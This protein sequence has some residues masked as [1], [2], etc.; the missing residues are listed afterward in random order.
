MKKI[1]LLTLFVLLSISLTYADHTSEYNLREDTPCGRDTC[2]IPIYGPIL[3]GQVCTSDRIGSL[4]TAGSVAEEC[5]GVFVGTNIRNKNEISIFDRTNGGTAKFYKQSSKN[6][7]TEMGSG[8]C[9]LGQVCNNGCQCETVDGD[10]D[11]FLGSSFAHYTNSNTQID[12]NDKDASVFPGADEV[13]NLKDDNCDGQVDEGDVCKKSVRVCRDTQEQDISNKVCNQGEYCSTSSFNDES[14]CKYITQQSDIGLNEFFAFFCDE[15]LQ[16]GDY[17]CIRFVESSFRVCTVDEQDL[18]EDNQDNDCDGRIDNLDTDCGFVVAGCNNGQL[19]QGEQCDASNLN[20]ATCQTVSSSFTGGSLS[21][22]N[23]CQFDTSQC[24]TETFICSPEEKRV[25]Y[26]AD[27][28]DEVSNYLETCGINGQWGSCLPQPTETC[29]NGDERACP[30]VLGICEG[31]TQTCS[32]GQWQAC[33]YGSNFNLVDSCS[34]SLDNNCDGLIDENCDCNVGDTKGCSTNTGVCN[35]GTQICQENGKWSSICGG[36]TLPGLEICDGIDNNCEGG[37]DEGCDCTNQGSTKNCGG[38]NQGVCKEGTQTCSLVNGLLKW[39]VCDGVVLPGIEICDNI[40]N[41]CNGAVD[42][43]CQ[44]STGDSRSCGTPI[45]ACTRGTQECLNSLW[46]VCLGAILPINELCGDNI[47]NDCDGSTDESCTCNEGDTRACALNDGVCSGLT[48]TCSNGAFTSCNYT[49]IQNY[50]RIETSCLDNKDND[51]DGKIDELDTNCQ[52][53]GESCSD[54]TNDNEC[55]TNKPNRCNDGVL[56]NKCAICGCDTEELCRPDGSCIISRPRTQPQQTPPISSKDSDGDGLTDEEE[57]A[58]GYDPFNPD[59]DGD[60]I[61]D[62]ED[63]TP[64]CNENGVC[65]SEG[66]YSETKNNC[67]VDCQEEKGINLW[68]LIIIL[69]IILLVLGGLGYYY[70]KT[71]KKG[72]KKDDKKPLFPFLDILKKRPRYKPIKKQVLEPIPVFKSNNFKEHANLQ[73]L[74]NYIKQGIKKGHSLSY[75][76]SRS[77][78]VGWYKEEI[79]KAASLPSL[80]HKKPLHKKRKISRRLHHKRK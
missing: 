3:Y 20:G 69:L 9:D 56:E 63:L 17:G 40:D 35:S 60:G 28:G 75:L 42:E 54:G 46:S 78:N 48:Q 33:D 5:E 14:S 44:C 68:I 79:N 39:G 71:K 13:C 31:K 30:R 73:D 76:K 8:G 32:N 67:P 23:N 2:R 41:S 52:G 77:L 50:E 49:S 10:L 19:D 22:A 29:T 21:C 38:P 15:Y 11:G 4:S 37:V 58:L 72:K 62:G 59:T 24:T 47:D 70:W 66:D 61:L 12:C 16:D 45:G 74:Q 64:L 25:C 27:G 1:I 80:L 34:D 6:F 55:S 26:P 36:S 57:L 18:C 53:S 65:D 51:C 43:G 7:P